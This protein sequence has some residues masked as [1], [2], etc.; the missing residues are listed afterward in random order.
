MTTK[1]NRKKKQYKIYDLE[2]ETERKEFSYALIEDTFALIKIPNKYKCSMSNLFDVFKKI[3]KSNKTLQC[4]INEQYVGYTSTIHLKQSLWF[5]LNYDNQTLF[6][7]LKNKKNILYDK[8][9]Q[10][11]KMVYKAFKNYNDIADDALHAILKY[12]CKDEKSY[13]Q[14]WN[15]LFP[16]YD[17]NKNEENKNEENKNGENKKYREC[18]VY[19]IHRKLHDLSLNNLAV[20][21]YYGSKNKKVKQ[22]F[23]EKIKNNAINIKN[24]ENKNEKKEEKFPCEEHM[25]YTLITLL[26][27][28]EPGLQ[29]RDIM[30]FEW[31]NI[32]NIILENNMNRD[33]IILV[34][35]G[36]TLGK[37]MHDRVSCYH[38]VKNLYK[39]QNRISFPLFCYA[40]PNG[41]IDTSLIKPFRDFK[42]TLRDEKKIICSEYL[43]NNMHPSVN[44]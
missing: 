19:N 18:A 6:P 24:D 42:I 23:F 1:R 22:G 5:Y 41:I 30:Y 11:E 43:A 10:N 13:I 4:E 26:C 32:E 16:N 3:F 9:K 28:N 27:A 8:N 35:T 40:D 21:E 2:N 37:L 15:N 14:C 7:P 20:I 29:V 12:Q 38:S 34:I 17:K 36:L 44:F 25:D 39:T 33:E 31:I